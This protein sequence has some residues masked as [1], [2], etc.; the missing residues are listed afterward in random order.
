MLDLEYALRSPQLSRFQARYRDLP[1]RTRAALRR[2]E[3][4]AGQI[5]I[6]EIGALAPPSF[7]PHLYARQ[8]GDRV[9]VGVDTRAKPHA[10]FVNRGTGIYAGHSS[11][12]VI[13]R[14][15]RALRF[16]AGGQVR[17]ARRV[18]IRGMR[19]RHFME[20]GLRRARPRIAR[21]VAV[22]QANVTRGR[23]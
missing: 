2:S 10:A 3:S 13:P 4:R 6:E 11:W 12:T 19:G 21:S 20:E 17:F 16:M 14:R 9:R 15:A 7:R 8:D 18:T 5:V 22:S 1:S 23:G